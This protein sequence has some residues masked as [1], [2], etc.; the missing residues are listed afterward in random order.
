MSDMKYDSG[1]LRD[2]ASKNR[3]SGEAAAGA[4]RTL[5]GV[6]VDAHPFGDVNNAGSFAG[7]VGEAHQHHIAGA[8]RFPSDIEGGRADKTATLG[9]ELTS[10]TT[11]VAD[12]A[13]VR[14]VA[15]GMS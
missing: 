11:T 8:P 2:G 13:A 5:S 14:R 12:Q 1:G 9:D 10:A 15:D 6:S 4:A 3:Q 7:A